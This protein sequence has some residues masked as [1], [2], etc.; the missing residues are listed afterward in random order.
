MDVDEPQVKLEANDGKRFILSNSEACCSHA[1]RTLIENSTNAA[2]DVIYLRV[3]DSKMLTLV[4]DWCKAH[5]NDSSNDNEPSDKLYRSS[6]IDL[7]DWEKA[8]LK[9]IPEDDLLLLIHVSNY[10]DVRRLFDATCQTIAK[11]WEGK[12]VDEIRKLYKIEGDFSLEEEQQMRQETK[13]LG[14]DD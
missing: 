12:K 5:G 9:E 1:L 6:N 3:V 8:F 4:V 7:S 2:P 13:K 10:L 14:L 11:R